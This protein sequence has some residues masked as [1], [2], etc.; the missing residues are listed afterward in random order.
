MRAAIRKVI[1]FEFGQ[2]QEPND[3]NVESLH[4]DGQQRTALL[5]TSDRAARQ[6][7]PRW[8]EQAGLDTVVTDTP[9]RA[10]E[11]GR[12][13]RPD[14]IITDASLQTGTSTLLMSSLREL[15]SEPV[16][17]IALCANAGDIVL[18]ADA[19]ATDIVR[20]PFEWDVITRRAVQAVRAHEALRNLTFAQQQF[21]DLRAA[22][23][24]AEQEHARSAGIDPL[25][26]LPDESRFRRLA[27][28]AMSARGNA[29][30]AISTIVIGIDHFRDVNQAIGFVNA[31]H[32]LRQFAQRLGA[33]LCE[34]EVFGDDDGG[35][36]TAISGRLG[37][38]RFAVQIANGGDD[39]VR[40][41]FEAML[42]ELKRP[43]RVDGQSIYLTASFGSATW[44]RFCDSADELLSCAEAA[45]VV[46]REQGT[47]LQ[48]W[49]ARLRRSRADDFKLDCLLRAA[50]R[51]RELKLHY[52]PITDVETGEVVA[53]EALLRWQH[54]TEGEIPPARF[55]PVAERTGLMREIGDFVI[56]TACAQLRDWL[57]AGMDPIRIAINMSLCQLL[58]GD[59]VAV[60]A[61]ALEHYDIPA[62]LL[63]IELS[64]RGVLNQ[65]PEVVGEIRR[66]KK[67][68]VRIS[69][70]DFGTGQAA[71]AYLK[72][73]PIDV[74]KIDRSYV[75][76]DGR[77]ERH[78]AIASGIVALAQRLDATVIA[79]GVETEDQLEMLRSW[80][81]EECQGFLFSRALPS[82]E[83]FAQYA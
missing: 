17:L 2:S 3:L 61:E 72:D 41:F 8:L 16:P 37:G 80:G 51:G 19:R 43:F 48:A 5:A 77:S 82:H 10:L 55:V 50:I 31:N 1:N 14:L 27:H 32:L 45:M 49:N 15:H 4:T 26:E 46:A 79:E 35:T 34:R 29:G 74:I 30:K 76:G 25:T 65:R 9:E 78:E 20:R 11:R 18:A 73:L 53:A 56:D 36:I 23:M 67:L 6:W 44:P 69:I 60:A 24:L 13:A 71:L 59:V 21:E 83:F 38:A 22:A 47:G 70:D 7:A 52:Q 40:S 68:G 39:H 62:E 75:S 64:E 58:R 81:S 57:D 33:V 28:S 66:L 42:Q 63:E 54:P 12:E